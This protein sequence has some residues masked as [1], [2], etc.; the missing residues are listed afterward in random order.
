MEKLDFSACIKFGNYHL[1]KIS[2]L[3]MNS[4]DSETER[5]EKL[6]QRLDEYIISYNQRSAPHTGNVINI[7]DQRLPSPR[8]TRMRAQMNCLAQNIKEKFDNVP[9]FNIIFKNPSNNK[10]VIIDMFGFPI[11]Q[12]EYNIQ[13]DI[14]VNTMCITRDGISCKSDFLSTIRSIYKRTGITRIDIDKM[15]ENLENKTLIFSDKTKIYNQ[16]VNF[17]GFRTKILACG[18]SEIS[19]ENKICDMYVEHNELCP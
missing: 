15:K 13:D 8:M 10:Y 17:I 12:N 18:Y 3:T 11:E 14:N 9:H 4:S 16:L 2:E 6:R 19:A 7:T 5:L 1:V